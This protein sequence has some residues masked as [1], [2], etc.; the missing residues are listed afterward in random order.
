MTTIREQVLAG[1]A[2][3]DYDNQRFVSFEAPTSGPAPMPKAVN[4]PAP[5]PPIA[6]DT[7]LADTLERSLQPIRVTSLLE[8][9]NRAAVLFAVRR[10][11]GNQLRAAAILGVNRV[12]MRKWCNKYRVD[13]LLF[14]GRP[15]VQEEE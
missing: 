5:P 4:L 12:T 3:P 6:I 13:P 15:R 8:H 1:T 9:T 2:V 10:A 7:L 11:K 14:G